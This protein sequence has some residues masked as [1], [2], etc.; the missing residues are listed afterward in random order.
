MLSK[1][2]REVVE[3]EEEMVAMKELKQLPQN[4][5]ELKLSRQYTSPSA[6]KR[7]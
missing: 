3:K 6:L 7:Y 1:L 5:R 4:S 2:E